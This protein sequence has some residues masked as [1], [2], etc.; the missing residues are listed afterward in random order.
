V[1]TPAILLLSCSIYIEDNQV[2]C[3]FR[4]RR[5][6]TKWPGCPKRYNN[7]TAYTFTHIM[8]GHKSLDDYVSN[9][10]VQSLEME[11][12]G[13]DINIDTENLFQ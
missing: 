1:I 5:L 2:A 9:I 12:K 4:R 11:I 6:L 13:G 7:N 8:L 3:L 10:V